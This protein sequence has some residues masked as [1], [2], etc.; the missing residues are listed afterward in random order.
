MLSTS[1]ADTTAP[2]VP[3]GLTATTMS[4]SQI[5]LS[6]SASTDNVGVAG[7][8]VYRNGVSIATVNTLSFTDSSFL[9]SN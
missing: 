4:S 8:A 7:Y 5:G 3:S 6:W 1:T 2:T 9:E